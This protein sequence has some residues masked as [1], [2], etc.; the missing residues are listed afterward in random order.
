[1]KLQTLGLFV[2]L[3]IFASFLMVAIPTHAGTFSDDFTPAPSPLW[4]NYAGNWTAVDGQ[5]YAQSANNN[6]L[7]STQ[8]PFVMG[9]FTATVTVDNLTDGG[10]W[11]DADGTNQNGILLVLGGNNYG[12]GGRGGDAGTSIYWT[13][14]TNGGG[15][16]SIFG[17]A[18]NVFT[19]GDNYTI[20]VTGVGDIYSAYINGASTPTTTFTTSSFATGQIGLYDDQPNTGA[21]G[22]GPPMTFSNFSVTASSVPEPSTLILGIAGLAGLNLS[23]LRKKFPPSLKR[24]GR[25]VQKAN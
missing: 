17:E 3:S 25:D 5:Y 21:G 12:Q 4:N 13:T 18:T 1:M 7:T 20:T 19:P 14:L 6:P 11:I 10:I 23:T 16:S 15:S 22:S 24:S 9:D 2:P 8:L